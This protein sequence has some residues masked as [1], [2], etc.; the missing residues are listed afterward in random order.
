M[1]FKGKVVLVTG[2]SRGIGKATALLFAKEGASIVVDYHVSEFELNAKENAATVVS[3]IQ[4]SGGKAVAIE[5]DVSSEDEVKQ[6]FNKAVKEFGKIDVLVNN[7]GIVYDE[8][9]DKKSAEHWKRT[10]EV[11]LI[12]LF[13]CSKQVAKVMKTGSIINIASTNAINSFNPESMDYDAAKA[14]I[15][16]LTK[17][18]AKELAPTIRVNS[19]APGWVDTDMNK[20]LSKEF[21]KEETN[22]IYL[23]RFAT[24]EEIAKL[25]LFLA[26]DDAAYLT[27]SNIVI[28][29]GH[30]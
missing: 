13:L 10:L 6:L 7:A 29:G 16:T 5:C 20:N 2:A 27:G 22:K 9:F 30:D 19:V 18:L 28:D 17:N 1:K 24:P 11:N 25:I 23:K 14:G 21:I 15:L 4:K 12:G 8:P 3:E 26:S